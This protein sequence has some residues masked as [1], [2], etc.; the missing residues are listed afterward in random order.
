MSFKQR[1]RDAVL[2][3]GTNL[4]VGIDPDLE[5]R[6]A[7]ARAELGRLGASRYLE[8]FG[9]LLV[10]AASGRAPAVKAQSAYFEAA[11]PEGFVALGRV[12]AYAKS[13]NVLTILDAKRGDIAS[14]MRAYGRAAFEVLGADAMTVTPYMGFDVIEPLIVPW[15]REDRGV[16]VVWV[17][18]ND[19]GALVQ[20]ATHERVLAAY[21]ELTRAKRIDGACGLVLGATRAATLTPA[22]LASLRD[23]ALLVPGVGAQGGT[24]DDA[25][26]GVLAAS[27]CSLVN[28]SRGLLSTGANAVTCWQEL[29]EAVRANVGIYAQQLSFSRR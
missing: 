11:G 3:T 12:I 24:I 4:C 20:D 27:G 16:Y 26:S 15:L 13:K 17:S 2:R 25:F 8:T 23:E 29:G 22:T 1:L 18:S 7:F 14:T 19:S 28:V 5:S 10:D 9:C 21:R 6:D